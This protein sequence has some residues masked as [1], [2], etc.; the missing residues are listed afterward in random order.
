MTEEQ[1]K[2]QTHILAGSFWEN[3]SYTRELYRTKSPGAVKQYLE[4][5]KIRRDWIASQKQLTELQL[6]QKLL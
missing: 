4:T 6:K 3:W 2:L 5:Q 1:L